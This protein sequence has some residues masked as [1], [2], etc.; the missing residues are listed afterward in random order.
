MQDNGRL[1]QIMTGHVVIDQQHA[2]LY[3]LVN[4]L[5]RL[6]AEMGDTTQIADFIYGIL[7]YATTHFEVEEALMADCAYPGLARQHELHTAFAEEVRRM[8]DGYRLEHRPSARELHV[9]MRRWI[10]EHVENEDLRMAEF[11][12]AQSC[13]PDPHDASRGS[14]PPYYPSR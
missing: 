11:V 1:D 5:A 8:A 12:R 2:E 10:D 4:A 9:F 3:R 7:R 14:I 13:A 6:A